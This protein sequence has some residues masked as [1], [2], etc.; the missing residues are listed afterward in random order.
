[1]RNVSTL[2]VLRL[3]LGISAGALKKIMFPFQMGFSEFSRLPC[4]TVEYYMG[5]MVILSFA[6]DRSRGLSLYP[7]HDG[8]QWK[9]GLQNY[10]VPTVFT[11]WSR[12]LSTH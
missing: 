2:I 8:S 10:W 4:L 3:D 11:L 6:S 5:T 7:Y 12:Q 9:K 1:M